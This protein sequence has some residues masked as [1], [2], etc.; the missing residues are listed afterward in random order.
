MM[1][2]ILSYAQNQSSGSYTIELIFQIASIVGLWKMFEKAGEPGWPAIIP[3]YNLYK[4]CEITMGYGWYCLRLLVFF[5]PIVGWIGGFYFLY[6]ICK[7]T[8]QAYGQS[9]GW[10]FGYLLLSPIFYC[11]TG[12]GDASYYGP[13]GAND[14]R[15]GGARDAK[16]VNFE[17]I[18]ND[19]RT[20]DTD[21]IRDFVKQTGTDTNKSNQTFV[22]QT[23]SEESLEDTEETVDFIFDEPTE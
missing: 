16:T 3:V 1:E 5:I 20:S 21:G 18:K 2:T 17:V 11:L 13:F 9:E 14:N 8:A 12:F 19:Q 15:T 4:L 10:A 23:A 6:Q 22:K 7:A